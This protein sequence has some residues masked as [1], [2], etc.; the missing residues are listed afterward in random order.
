MKIFQNAA[1][2]LYQQKQHFLNN[3]NNINVNRVEKSALSGKATQ[4]PTT[5]QKSLSNASN[6]QHQLRSV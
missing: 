3:L 6:Q 5:R 2:Y 1:L 4:G